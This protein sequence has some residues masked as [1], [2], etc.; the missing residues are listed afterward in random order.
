[1]VFHHS[2][3]FNTSLPASIQSPLATSPTTCSAHPANSSIFYSVLHSVHVLFLSFFII[4]VALSY[5]PLPTTFSRIGI[6]NNF[7]SGCPLRYQPFPFASVSKCLDHIPIHF[8]LGRFF[9]SI[10]LYLNKP[11]LFLL[12]LIL[13]LAGDIEIN[14]GPVSLTSVNLSHLNIRSATSVTPQLY[15]PTSIQETISDHKLDILSLSE[16]WLPLDTL[17]SVLNSLTPPNFSILSSP[18]ASGC[19]GGGL[20]VIYRSTLKL[21]K[22][23]LSNY[24]SFESLCVRFTTTS[25]TKPLSFILLTIYRPPSSSK[26]IFLSEF[27]TLL[28]DLATSPS[29]LIITGDF[30]FHVDTPDCPSSSPFLNLL[31]AFSLMQHITFPTHTSGHTLDLLITRSI[32]NLISSI[33]SIDLSLSDH[34]AIMFSITAPA[35]PR[36]QRITKSVRNYRSIDISNFSRDILSSSLHTSHPTSLR[37]YLQLFNSVL[38]DLLDKY[39][40][41]KTI[42]CPS[43]SHKPFI[44][45]LIL[46][47][48]SKRS[49]LETIHR[50]HRTTNT[51]K[52]FK[53]QSRLVSRLIAN[54]KRSY[55]RNMISLCSNQPKKT[56]VHYELTVV[57]QCSSCPSKCIIQFNS[58]NFLP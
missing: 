31:D 29:E 10:L 50:R 17:P 15:K 8:L 25:G 48:K 35:Q 1:M 55:Y 9:T 36:T 43:R 44:T 12:C 38:S 18:R 24:T 2:S 13:L 53:L 6:T 23:L 40:P 26:P 7:A 33:D 56:L 54:S 49:K 21:T 57:P 5:F 19:R 11:R 14:P 52:D 20:A 34:H 45:P 51:E 3:H 47:E 4:Y 30:N 39:A 41:L 32:S 28:E 46:D 37:S 27:A 58:R 16:T 42:T 22:I